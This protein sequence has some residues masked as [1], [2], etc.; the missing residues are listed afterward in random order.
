MR[1]GE[2]L[3]SPF[4]DFPFHALRQLA[5]LPGFSVAAVR[6]TIRR[7][8]I[9][10]ILMRLDHPAGFEAQDFQALDGKSVCGHSACGSRANHD[11]VVKTFRRQIKFL[12][13]PA[14]SAVPDAYNRESPA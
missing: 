9:V 8:V 11:H 1:N 14:A 2:E 7:L 10:K 6:P 4:I 13:F 12:P 3:V 5:I